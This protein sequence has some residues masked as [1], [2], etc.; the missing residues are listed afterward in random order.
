MVGWIFYIMDLMIKFLYKSVLH[1]ELSISDL[2]IIHWGPRVWM[3]NV[4]IEVLD[5]RNLWEQ[6][7]GI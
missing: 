5:S 6:S 1:N 3:N 4:G 7:S 2:Y